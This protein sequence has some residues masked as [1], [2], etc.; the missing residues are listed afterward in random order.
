VKEYGRRS[1]GGNKKGGGGK[2]VDYLICLTTSQNN[3][4]RINA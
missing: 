4:D 1:L 3:I 2:F